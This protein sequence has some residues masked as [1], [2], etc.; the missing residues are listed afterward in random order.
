VFRVPLQKLGMGGVTT[1]RR[2]KR[3]N[4]DWLA[5]G[6][7]F[8]LNHIEEALGLMFKLR[9]QPD[10]YLEFDTSA[11]LR[12]SFKER[13]EGWAAG[14]KGGI[15]ARNEA[16]REFELKPVEGGNEPWVQQ[17]DVP[18]SVA[19]ENAEN[20]PQPPALPAPT[21]EPAGEQADDRTFDD[22]LRAIDA[23]TADY[24][25]QSLH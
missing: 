17:Q 10:E 23:K 11:L 19:Y 20:P 14:T 9:G 8:I 22:L 3:L 2:R 21:Q 25:Q 7:G 4:S 24:A 6:L 16:R 12:S 18:L 15:F 1:M 13:V 5:S